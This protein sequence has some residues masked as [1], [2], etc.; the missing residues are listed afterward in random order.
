MTRGS[1][2]A[3]PAARA[4]ITA[5]APA[6]ALLNRLRGALAP[7]LQALGAAFAS[8]GLPPTFWTCVGLALAL[9]AA[10]SYGLGGAW[11]YA[12]VAGGALILASGFFDMVDGQVARAAGKTSRRGAFLDS[13][14]DKVAEVAIFGGILAGGLADARLV[15]LAAA[16]SLLVSY[17]RSRA[18]S[19]GVDLGGTGIGE[20]AERLLVLA[21]VGMAGLVEVAVAAVAALAAVTLVHRIAATYR[22]IGA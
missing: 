1:A 22:R 3:A 14:F 20:R 8:T 6:C 2:A 13:V 21:V 17:S 9:A 16:L 5:A 11:Q 7:G 10:V 12:A 18:D 19:L 15:F 4:F